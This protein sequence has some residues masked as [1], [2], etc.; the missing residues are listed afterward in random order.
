MC[1]ILSAKVIWATAKDAYVTK[2]SQTASIIVRKFR[3][4]IERCLGGGVSVLGL[5]KFEVDGGT[6]GAEEAGE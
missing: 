5:A 4:H 3:G 1:V 2:K 6:G